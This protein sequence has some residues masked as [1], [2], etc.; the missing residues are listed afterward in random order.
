MAISNFSKRTNLIPPFPTGAE[1]SAG[2]WLPWPSFRFPFG[3]FSL[4]INSLEA[5]VK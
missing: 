4:F 3:L 1:A 5:L 2:L